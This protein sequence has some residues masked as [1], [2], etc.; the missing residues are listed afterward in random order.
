MTDHAAGPEAGRQLLHRVNALLGHWMGGI[1]PCTC[2]RCT[3]VVAHI[4]AAVAAAVAEE[5]ARVRAFCKQPSGQTY[6]ELI[7]TRPAPGRREG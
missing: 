2:T 7:G 4:D 5:R 6:C 3:D 1:N